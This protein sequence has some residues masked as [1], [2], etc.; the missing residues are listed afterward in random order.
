MFQ[1]TVNVV[2]KG[3][4]SFFRLEDIDQGVLELVIDFVFRSAL[5]TV[6]CFSV[7][8]ELHRIVILKVQFSEDVFSQLKFQLIIC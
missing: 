6:D 4:N 1:R 5:L 8:R 7:K 3:K 2:G